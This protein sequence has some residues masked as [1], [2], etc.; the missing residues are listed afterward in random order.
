MIGLTQEHGPCRI[1]ND[2]DTVSLNPYSWNERA[3]ILYIDQP[4]GVGFSTGDKIV[5]TSAAAAQDIWTFI[6]IWL[7]D[8]KFSRYKNRDLAIWTESYATR[9][10]LVYSKLTSMCT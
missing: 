6:Q 10:Y 3:N 8:S 4:V 7:S 5:G 2:T 1:N 9:R